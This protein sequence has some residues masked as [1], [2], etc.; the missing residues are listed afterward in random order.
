M[1]KTPEEKIALLDELFRI[2]Y[3]N[4]NS[5]EEDPELS[6]DLNYLA[7]A[8]VQDDQCDWVDPSTRALVGILMV[9]CLPGHPVW[10]YIRLEPAVD[11]ADFKLTAEQL[12][13]KYNPDGGGGHP[14]WSRND[15]RMTVTNENTISGYWDWVTAQL[16]Q[17]AYEREAELA[18]KKAATTQDVELP[19]DKDRPIPP[20]KLGEP[21]PR[22]A[23]GAVPVNMREKYGKLKG[24]NWGTS[25][26]DR[27][28]WID[29]AKKYR[30]RSGYRVTDLQLALRA[31]TGEEVT[32]PV[33]G[34]VIVEEAIR[35]KKALA[36][37]YVWTL[38]GRSSVVKD[39][40]QN[41]LVPDTGEPNITKEPN[42]AS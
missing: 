40:D 22:L 34:T 38:D 12:D 17:Q 32:Y 31:S 24:L 18:A 30:T 42:R 2:L 14:V 3:D 36:A 4:T 37:N 1:T 39:S 41:D 6:A 16:A 15:W 8:I 10:S 21:P 23:A 33:K 13:D 29:P 20:S 27:A 28:D 19:E 11:E 7:A 35:D 25:V 9:H 26:I 5:Y